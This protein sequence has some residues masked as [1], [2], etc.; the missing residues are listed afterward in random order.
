[1]GGTAGTVVDSRRRALRVGHHTSICPGKRAAFRSS[2][3]VSRPL[4]RRADGYPG[5][6]G[7]LPVHLEEAES[8]KAAAAWS[9]GGWGDR[10]GPAGGNEPAQ[11]RGRLLC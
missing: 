11:G 5:I 4:L 2:R 7:G 1:A 8:V 3:R 10:A 9:L 6:I